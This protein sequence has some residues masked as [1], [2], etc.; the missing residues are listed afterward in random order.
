MN[1][2]FPYDKIR[3]TQ[4]DF[5]KEIL[6][7]IETK[8]NIIAHVPVGVG[9]TAAIFSSIIPLLLK[10]DLT[11][12]FLTPRHSQHKLAIE[13]IKSIKNKFNINIQVS[14]FI[15]K[16]HICLQDGVEKSTTSEFYEYCRE[17]R[18]NGACEYYNNYKE[19]TNQKRVKSFLDT[20]QPILHI[21]EL[22]RESKIEKLCPYE[23][24]SDLA[25]TSKIIIA[26][27]NHILN[28]DIREAFMKRTDKLLSNSI[29]VFDEAHNINKKSRDLLTS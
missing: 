19:K 5:I 8:N 20:I 28:S 2:L 9:K 27:Y 16:K 15:G 13:T 3:N 12:I 4:E 25:K 6:A 18:D 11:L 24:A 23:I 14:D 17:L 7:S 26:D 22:K 29:L 21:E 10:K 1:I